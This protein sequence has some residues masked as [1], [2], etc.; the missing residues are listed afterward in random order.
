MILLKGIY[1]ISYI[2]LP[3]IWYMKDKF[4][5][6]WSRISPDAHH[7]PLAENKK[8]KID[9][10]HI[11]NAQYPSL[12]YSSLNIKNA[13]RPHTKKKK[14]VE[15]SGD[16]IYSNEKQKKYHFWEKHWAYK[17]YSLSNKVMTEQ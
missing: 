7:L 6:Y 8:S 4:R 15:K 16:I 17:V 1:L 10:S 2:I 11:S 13:S 9:N 12:V 14:Q 3:F 5:K